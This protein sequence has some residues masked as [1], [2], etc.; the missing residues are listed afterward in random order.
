M[1]AVSI[2]PAL[3]EN[4]TSLFDQNHR[5]PGIKGARFYKRPAVRVLACYLFYRPRTVGKRTVESSVCQKFWGKK[6]QLTP[7]TAGLGYWFH[8]QMYCIACKSVISTSIDLFLSKCTCVNAFPPALHD[9]NIWLKVG[10]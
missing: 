7:E 5:A 8:V 10:Q 4:Y 1:N 9:S 2:C 6:Q 3:L